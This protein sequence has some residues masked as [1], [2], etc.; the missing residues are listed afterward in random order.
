MRC[1]PFEWN[2]R[3]RS[4]KDEFGPHISTLMILRRQTP[5]MLLLPASLRSASTFLQQT[6]RRLRLMSSISYRHVNAMDYKP[7][8]PPPSSRLRQESH[9]CQ[10]SKTDIT[11][12]CSLTPRLPNR[13]L[14]RSLTQPLCLRLTQ[15]PGG[16]RT[17]LDAPVQ[18][19]NTAG[20]RCWTQRVGFI[21]HIPFPCST[22]A[23]PRFAYLS[24]GLPDD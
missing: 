17:F 13:H 7:P 23:L 11:R 6:T 16:K 24:L 2:K 21:P 22:L 1:L 5:I 10:R 14:L 18:Y 15:R 12:P 9:T 20:S 8:P 3:K 4:R 19:S